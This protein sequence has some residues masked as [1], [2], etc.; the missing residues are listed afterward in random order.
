MMTL[1]WWWWW[2]QKWN[3]VFYGKQQKQK[4]C[5][6]FPGRWLWRDRL[7]GSG[8]GGQE[9][10]L[11]LSH[12]YTRKGRETQQWSVWT[13]RGCS[14]S[15]P[16]S[17]QSPFHHYSQEQWHEALHRAH[18]LVH[19]FEVVWPW[20][21][22]LSVQQNLHR[23]TVSEPFKIHLKLFLHVCVTCGSFEQNIPDVFFPSSLLVARPCIKP[24]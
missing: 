12:T 20:I 13:H 6:R 21:F 14:G 18:E 9:I 16:K 8:E 7:W 10:S 1:G 23:F 22:S 19:C 17:E 3:V 24:I 4:P 15:M 11:S 5:W 2:S